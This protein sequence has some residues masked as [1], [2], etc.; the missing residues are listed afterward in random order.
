M[1]QGKIDKRNKQILFYLIQLNEQLKTT[2]RLFSVIF[3]GKQYC[4]YRFR[5]SKKCIKEQKPQ[6]R[7]SFKL[8]SKYE[9]TKNQSGE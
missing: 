3:I 5:M 6:K 2:S 4:V 8:K 1:K 7:L 9:K